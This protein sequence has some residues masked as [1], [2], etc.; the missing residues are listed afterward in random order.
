MHFKSVLKKKKSGAAVIRTRVA[1][2]P[3]MSDSQ[4]TLQPRTSKVV[5]CFLYKTSAKKIFMP[6]QGKEKRRIEKYLKTINH[7]AIQIYF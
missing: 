1:C 2:T 7:F 4:A 5:E 3:S 6:G